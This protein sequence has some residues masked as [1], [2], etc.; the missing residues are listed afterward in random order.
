[1]EVR[2]PFLTWECFVLTVVERNRV[3]AITRKDR[4]VTACVGVVMA[5]QLALGIYFIFITATT[6]GRYRIERYS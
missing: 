1:M 6:P 5:S 4:R 3:Y 2:P